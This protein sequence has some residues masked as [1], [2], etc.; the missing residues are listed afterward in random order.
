MRTCFLC[1]KQGHIVANC[2]QNKIGT[3]GEVEGGGKIE[4]VEQGKD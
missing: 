1:G 3:V 4:E 2:V